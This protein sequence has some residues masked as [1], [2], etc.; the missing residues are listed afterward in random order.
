M[1]INNNQSQ[2]GKIDAYTKDETLDN[3]TLQMYKLND[4]A[5]P[6]T[7]FQK[8]AMPYGYYGFDV[9]TV[10]E[11]G[12]AAPFVI[13]N[14]LTDFDGNTVITDEYGRCAVAVSDS[15]SPTVS[16]N[17]HFGV[18]SKNE[19]IT[20]NSEYPFTPITIVLTRD[21]TEEYLITT[22]QTVQM[23]PDLSLDICVVGGGGGC[24]KQTT[25]HTDRYSGGGG[26]YVTNVMNFTTSGNGAFEIVIGSGGANSSSSSVKGGD[27]GT[28]TITY[29]GEVIASALGGGGGNGSSGGV[30]NGN[31]GNFLRTGSS[32]VDKT[33]ISG[34]DG[35]VHVFND[36]TRPLPGGGGSTRGLVDTGSDAGDNAYFGTAG[37]DYGGATG[38][39]G[40][41]G[42]TTNGASLKTKGYSGAVY[43]RVRL[44]E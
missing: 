43:I 9:T 16:I 14:G 39:G 38:P 18:I 34:K 15:D 32:G 13:L 8:L 41:A 6:K 1:V 36:E 44:K 35:T 7:V 40:G 10:F 33:A 17:N 25:S 24:G 31:G 11:D 42:Y 2:G 22:S 12:G 19:T 5:T 28:T 4:E 20:S 23:L 29:K 21:T 27:G 37:K 26:G 30:G 3:S